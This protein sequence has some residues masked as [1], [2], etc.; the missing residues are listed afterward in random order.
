MAEIRGGVAFV[1]GGTSGIGRAT[2]LEFAKAGAHVVLTGRR[3]EQGEA[4]AGDVRRQG[5]QGVFVQADAASESDM[6]R[7]VE[8]ARR[9]RGRIDFA[10]N[11]AG[12][13]GESFEPLAEQSLDNYQRIFDVNVRGVF[14]AMKYEIAAMLGSGRGTIVN[15]ASVAGSVGFPGM[16]LYVAS[17]HA[18]IGLTRAAAL[19]YSKQGIR[20]NVVSPAAIETD[21]FDR[22]VSGNDAARSGMAAAHPIG[23]VGR[24]DE[25]ARAVLFLCSDAAS[26]VTGHDLRVDGGYTAQ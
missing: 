15:N 7:A 8:E 23:R 24:A 14:L 22:F 12:I 5:V 1:T 17:K 11:N 9:V 25:I 19:E 16:S 4:V 26:F 2:A 13:E 20:V 6:E 3:R 21:M 18:V 10:F